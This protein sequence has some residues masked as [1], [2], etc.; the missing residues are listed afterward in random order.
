VSSLWRH[1]EFLKFW[2]GAA[3]SDV[4]SQVT[5][6]AVPLIAALTLQ[7]TPWQM[8]P[9]GG[10]WGADPAGRTLRRRVGRS[11]E[12]PAGHDR[13]RSRPRRAAAGDSGGRGRLSVRLG[14]AQAAREHLTTA[15]AMYREIDLPFWLEQ[16]EREAADVMGAL[17]PRRS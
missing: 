5:L 1:R 11:R 4:G 9:R 15:T 12:A 14:K 3:I 17:P 10:G 6:L 2:A 7:A 16:A 13:H 8:A